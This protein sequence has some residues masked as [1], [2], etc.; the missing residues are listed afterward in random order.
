MAVI[1]RIAEFHEEIK[2]WRRDIHAHPETAFGLFPGGG[3]LWGA[4]A[5][6]GR[7]HGLVMEGDWMH[8][9]DPQA[10]DDAEARLAKAAETA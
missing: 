8:V 3:G 6:E 4:W 1:N 7:L 9:G 2:G 10:R 5:A